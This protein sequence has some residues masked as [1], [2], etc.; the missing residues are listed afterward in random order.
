MHQQ[1]NE[2]EIKAAVPRRREREFL[3]QLSSQDKVISGFSF[4]EVEVFLPLRDDV[5]EQN[6]SR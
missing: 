6:R 4:L 1:I 3:F 2:S 5:L